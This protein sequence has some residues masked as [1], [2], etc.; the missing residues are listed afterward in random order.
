[1]SDPTTIAVE[2]DGAL[3]HVVLNRPEKRN[4]LTRDTMLALAAA[5]REAEHDAGVRVLVLRAAGPD[6]CA[7][8][9]L[10]RLDADERPE[11]RFAREEE[12]LYGKA[13]ELRNFP[14]PTI[15]AVQG[16]CIAGGLLLSQMCDLIIASDDAYFYNPLVRMGGVALEVLMEPWDLGIRRAKRYLFTGERIPA[17]VALRL[18]MIT[19]VASRQALPAATAELARQVAAMPPLTMRLL[20]KSINHTQDLMG[21]RAALDHHFALHE[22]GHTTRESQRLLHEARE[23]RPLKEYFARRDEGELAP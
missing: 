23:R 14:K 16:G 19:D 2:R 6:F 7:G 4:A 21:M 1:M 17:D 13:L 15:A 22:F 5:L 11:E 8:F 3:L 10:S 20:K 9:D 18:G 12:E